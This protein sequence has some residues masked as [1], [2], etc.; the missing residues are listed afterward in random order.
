MVCGEITAF[1]S[2][3]LLLILALVGTT[4]ESARVSVGRSYADRSMK[5]AL[6]SL[7]TEYCINLWE[8]YHIFLL[9][10]EEN[11][12]E[13]MDYIKSTLSEYI[14]G[15]LHSENQTKDKLEFSMD[16][17]EMELKQIEVLD[18]V[19]ADEYEGELLLHEILEYEK[20]QVEEDF[21]TDEKDMV[22]VIE[23]TNTC[24]IVVEKQLEAEE[25]MA[26]V[27]LDI[28]EFISL[29]EEIAEGKKEILSALGKLEK[30]AKKILSKLKKIEEAEEKEE[31]EE[32]SY[33]KLE[34]LEEKLIEKT[35]EV[36]EQT[37]D[38]EGILSGI[39]EKQPVFAREAEELDAVYKDQKDKLSAESQR[40]FEKEIEKLKDYAEMENSEKS[41]LIGQ[42]LGE[43]TY[44]ESS[45]EVLNMV[46]E[47]EGLWIGGSVEE[48]EEYVE[49]LE[50]LKKEIKE[51]Q[52]QEIQL[53]YDL[54]D[55]EKNVKNPIDVFQKNYNNSILG[56]VVKDFSQISTKKKR[57]QTRIDEVEMES[58][59]AQFNQEYD[60][61]GWLESGADKQLQILLL[62]HYIE[63][64][65]KSYIS[66]E[67]EQASALDY[68][69]EYILGGKLSDKENLEI[70]LKKIV[71]LRTILN[72]TY[73]ITDTEKT[74]MAYITAMAL[75]G[76]SGMEPLVQMTKNIILLIWAAEEAII[77]AGALLQEK[78]VPI[79]KT[80]GTFQTSYEELLLFDRELV[81]RKI[82][83]IPETQA[84]VMWNYQQYLRLL[85]NF[86][87][88]EQKING[89]MEL[90][91]ENI[92]LRYDR[93][94]SL[95]N[96]IYGVEA[97]GQ[98][99]LEEKFLSFPFVQQLLNTE[100]EGFAIYNHQSYCY[101]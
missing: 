3:I 95:S 70:V 16:L 8:K 81:Q 75:I 63:T 25:K 37:A 74:E 28:L 1:L 73:I 49:I 99:F 86:C 68:E 101:Q 76:F 13:D 53:D 65:F 4:L 12:S 48:A 93:N 72:Y 31:E 85:F 100:G 90:I 94:F 96:C 38:A 61:I 84:G 51:N 58:E 21:L 67:N 62:T 89:V 56:L 14:N 9:E 32:I 57:M 2:M 71:F 55:T 15:T 54:K 52:R 79:F 40:A 5:N 18:I 42:V 27:N 30:E 7:Y 91:E 29:K 97:E 20:Y 10:G 88:K 43:E 98:F 17:L 6:E 22:K 45:E 33:K 60:G 83:E 92:K 24:M 34:R 19:R 80:K 66:Q 69:A 35:E 39:R 78:E 64:H 36:L 87:P 11:E 47:V 59:V 41:S 82:K 46:L 50:K 23:E 26:E 77:D 44:L